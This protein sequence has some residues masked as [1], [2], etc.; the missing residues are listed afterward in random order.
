MIKLSIF[1]FWIFLGV[2]LAAVSGLA[3][4]E[5]D[6]K[7]KR[8]LENTL[9]IP[10]SFQPGEAVLSG[11]ERFLKQE[12]ALAKKNRTNFWRP[13][14]SS[15]A[16]YCSSIEPNRKELAKILGFVGTREPFSAMT[17]D[18]TTASPA[19]L[20]QGHGYRVYAVQ[21]PVEGTVFG[22]GL[23]L[24]PDREKPLAQVV[25]IPHTDQTPEMLAGLTEGIPLESQFA[26]RLAENGCRVLIPTLVGREL[27]QYGTATLPDREYLDR[28][29]FP[30]GRPLIGYELE[31]IAAA[32]DWFSK[33]DPSGETK[34]G[35]FGYGDGGR[36]ALY[37]AALD[38]RIDVACTSGYFDS[39]ENLWQEPVDRNVFGLFKRFGDA[40]L[41]AMVAP[42]ALLVEASRGPE[43]EIDPGSA[44]SPGKLISPT[45]K[46]VHRE[47]QRAQSFLGPWAGREYLQLID[48]N[49]GNEQNQ[50]TEP[51]GSK[52]AINAFL[53]RLEPNRGETVFSIP[54]P[55]VNLS[56]DRHKTRRKRQIDQLQR[57]IISE[58]A[59]AKTT[60]K[61]YW[62]RLD[63]KSVHGFETS[64]DQYRSELSEQVFGR[65]DLPLLPPNPKTKAILD[66]RSLT[67]H[68]VILDVFSD[69]ITT[70]VLLVPKK[71]DANV[72]RPA[73]V[74]QAPVGVSPEKLLQ[75]GSTTYDGLA[76]TLVKRGFVVFLT[77]NLTSDAKRFEALNRRA[78]PLGKTALSILVPQHRQIVGWLGSLPE[79][80][81]KRIALW[82]IGSG[83]DAVMRVAP[84]IKNYSLVVGSLSTE[85]PSTADSPFPIGLEQGT[86]GK[87][88]H[89]E[90]NGTTGFS[91]AE[92]AALIAPRPLLIE[93]FGSKSIT[94][95]QNLLL[96]QFGSKSIAG[97]QN[98]LMALDQVGALYDVRLGLGNRFESLRI[99]LDQD[100]EPV[101]SE[102]FDF[103]QT[104]FDQPPRDP[105]A[106]KSLFDG[107]TLDGWKI[108]EFGGEG[109]VH[110]DNRSI[111]MEMGGGMTG[112]TYAG[113]VP[114]TNYELT[115]EA[116]RIDG[117]DF[118]AAVT[119][120]VDDS[121]C[122][123]INGGWGGTLIGL[124][125][126]DSLDASNNETMNFTTFEP[127]RWYQF[128][129]R[130][131]DAKIE[132]W[133]DD[134]K[135]V[136]IARSGSEFSVRS[137]VELCSPLGF[138]SWCT[139]GA[140]RDIRLRQIPQE[141]K[142][143]ETSDR[144]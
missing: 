127:N 97:T 102:T 134:K 59:K 82:G 63:T 39:R 124:S 144:P 100:D 51:F 95:N 61:A 121:F 105:H 57:Q 143:N 79:V 112:V 90:F 117:S 83:A 75:P 53:D 21:W 69:L 104:F 72:K 126:V 66:Q 110:A 3:M 42:R 54:L 85:E 38:D 135:V 128:R 37:A 27:G 32:I 120:P 14:F 33:Q 34:I 113:D 22:E 139:V 115:Y 99:E 58:L 43:G 50:A 19:Q 74:I 131:T 123:F 23:L 133:I 141:E 5:T 48:G 8:P 17:I 142:K 47:F 24:E 136:D 70:G 81:S 40:E 30:I 56:L 55:V 62:N 16:A 116:K 93:R 10:T 36:L 94:G 2:L 111:V 67:G 45:K 26:R 130:V 119:F 118:F 65:F 129:L 60:R 132:V 11:A 20:A 101:R 41:A 29:G 89:F 1:R 18:A 96:E 15:E 13:D 86:G 77:G 25:A 68:Q 35:A 92:L 87:Y 78:S 9:P 138:S 107:K 31:K 28:L 80:D 114:K 109:K 137:E 98:L 46:N 125:C 7:S 73:I 44:G 88:R 91:V 122:S 84:L 49:E 12:T 71:I 64:S 108:P 4:A 52:R 140:V 103:L 76:E 6:P 106:W